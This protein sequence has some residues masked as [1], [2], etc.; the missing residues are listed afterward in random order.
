MRKLY[1]LFFLVVMKSWAQDSIPFVDNAYLEDQLYINVNYNYL[2][3]TPDFFSQSGFSYGLGLG[4]IK[5][6]PV[7]KRRNVALG[8]GL[9]YAL[10]NYYFNVREADAPDP[11]LTVTKSNQATIHTL[12]LP[13][14]FRIRTSTAQKSRFW[15]FYPGLKL[16]Y[17]FVKNTDLKRRED[18]SVKDFIEVREF[19]Y[20]L[21]F[22]GGYNKWNFYFYYG[23]NSL[24]SNTK[25]N[26]IDF[27]IHDLR[28]GLIFY[29]L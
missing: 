11:D 29:I 23:L 3:N 7:N 26:P 16:G 13:I 10:N 27:D 17:V 24:F 28:F 15:R 14:E 21:T 2:P 22:S 18:F 1:L 5:D 4:F 9:G 19:L 25:T 6:F 20:G 12:D 8:A